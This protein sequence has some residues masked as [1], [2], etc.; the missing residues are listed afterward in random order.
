M[1]RK[2]YFRCKSNPNAAPLILET[3]WEAKEMAEHPDYERIDEFGEVVLDEI[4][5]VETGVSAPAA[6]AQRAAG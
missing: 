5:R 6:L 2:F 1:A 4:E 3:S